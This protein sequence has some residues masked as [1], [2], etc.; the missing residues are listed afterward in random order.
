MDEGKITWEAEPITISK[1]ADA[2]D[3]GIF[4]IY[5]EI[6]LVPPLSVAENIFLGEHLGSK[7]IVD[8]QT[9]YQESGRILSLLGASHINIHATLQSL[10]VAEQ[11]ADW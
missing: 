7:G 9:I 8:W 1:P 3:R 11:Q 5:Q 4:T 6:S 10:G 2:A